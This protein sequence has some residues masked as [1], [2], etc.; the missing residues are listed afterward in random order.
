MLL[1]NIIRKSRS[2]I[3]KRAYCDILL[4]NAT[5]NWMRKLHVATQ[6]YLIVSL[7]QSDGQGREAVLGGERLVRAG[8]QEEPDDG[9]VIL[10]R[11]HVQGGEPVL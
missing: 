2:T 5:A 3:S 1:Q 6:H 8:R 10:L 11:R 9:V 4:T 7:L